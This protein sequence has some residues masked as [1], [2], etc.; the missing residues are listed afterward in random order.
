MSKQHPPAPTASTV[1]PCPTIIQ[2]VGHPGTGRLPRAIAPPD[3][4]LCV[5]ES[6][7]YSTHVLAYINEISSKNI[8]QS[9]ISTFFSQ[10]HV[11]KNCNKKENCFRATS[12]VQLVLSRIVLII[13]TLRSAMLHQRHDALLVENMK[14][15]TSA[16]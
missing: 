6:E 15:S 10:L 2:I 13:M 16:K 8:Y 5:I 1:G 11:S 4:P 12:T 3:H 9:A 14:L 7:T